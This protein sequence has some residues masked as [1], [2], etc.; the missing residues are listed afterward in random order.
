[1]GVR[2]R[3]WVRGRKVGRADLHDP[4]EMGAN[5][6]RR[7]QQAVCSR[8]GAETQGFL[9]NDIYQA[10]EISLRLF[11]DLL[12]MATCWIW[13]VLFLPLLRQSYGLSLVSWYDESHWLVLTYLSNLLSCCIIFSTQS[14]IEFTG[15]LLRILYLCSAGIWADSF[16]FHNISFSSFSMRAIPAYEISL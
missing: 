3:G 2:I 6:E 5:K 12:I 8:A 1:M 7:P 10:E 13:K 11:N 16:S 15:I 9:T 14:L 4:L